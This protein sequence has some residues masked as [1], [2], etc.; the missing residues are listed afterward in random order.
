M[1]AAGCR[2]WRRGR[3]PWS[4]SDRQLK[5]FS[6]AVKQ[7]LELEDAKVHPVLANEKVRAPGLKLV[8]TT[9]LG[10]EARRIRGQSPETL[11]K[12]KT[13]ELGEVDP[14]PVVNEPGTERGTGRGVAAA[15]MMAATAVLV[16][17]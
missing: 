1:T 14:T 3:P 7:R 6:E 16:S 4:R 11:G 5:D 2:P 9:G 15:P 8:G 12:F 10:R 17:R 13:E